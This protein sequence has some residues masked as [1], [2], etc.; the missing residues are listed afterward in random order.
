MFAPVAVRRAALL[1]AALAFS[2]AAVGSADSDEDR[3]LRIGSRV[4]RSLVAADVEV[5]GKVAPDGR[6]P[7]VVYGP[8]GGRWTVE[9][10]SL[11]EH[12]E[13]EGSEIRDLTVVVETTEDASFGAL[14]APPAAVFLAKRTDDRELDRLV[15][16]G[17]EHHV[18]VFSPFEGDVERGVLGGLVVEARVRP[19]INMRTLEAS[20]VKL[21]PFFLR[22]SKV[23]P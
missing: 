7:L 21:K 13:A 19:L 14:A 22:A 10:V 5:G 3:R 11:I 8:A 20:R 18:V 17:I 16:Y 23:V 1:A 4:F 6:L 15:R 9:A 2:T 12:G